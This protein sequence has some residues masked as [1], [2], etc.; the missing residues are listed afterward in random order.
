MDRLENEDI[1]LIWARHFPKR[2]DSETSNS[3][4]LTLAMILRYPSSHELFVFLSPLLVFLFPFPF[5]RS[6]RTPALKW[7]YFDRKGLKDDNRFA[8][9]GVSPH[10]ILVSDGVMIWP[11]KWLQTF[12]PG[13][14]LVSGQ[15]HVLDALF[16]IA[17]GINKVCLIIIEGAHHLFTKPGSGRST[18]NRH[19][20]FMVSSSIATAPTSRRTTATNSRSD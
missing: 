7:H 17:G 2:A 19:S 18:I 5:C 9:D 10:P 4:C 8:R 1:G 6:I 20:R 16:F 3:L 12:G 15:I 13:M 14:R 11:P